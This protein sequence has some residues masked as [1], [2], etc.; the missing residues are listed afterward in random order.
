[1]SLLWQDTVPTDEEDDEVD[2]DQH[3][4][5]GRPAIRHDAIVHHRVPV[6][7]CQDLCS[8]ECEEVTDFSFCEQNTACAEERTNT[9]SARNVSSPETR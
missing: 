9:I 2:A 4:R 6:L 8:D 5:E 7:S 3:A 1:M